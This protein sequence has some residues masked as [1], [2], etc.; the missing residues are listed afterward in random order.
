MSDKPTLVSVPGAWHSTETW[1]KVFSI[2]EAKQFKCVSVAL[3]STAGN[4]ATTF[5]E[6][7][8]AVRDA[9]LEETKQGHDVVVVVHSYGGAVGQ[10]AIKGFS[11]PKQD[12]ASAGKNN[13]SGHVI[14]LAVMG[15]GFGQTG[16][17]F[18]DGLGGKPPPMWREDPSGF[19]VITVPARD[20]FYHDLPEEEGDY[21][22]S[23]LEKQALNALMDPE[24]GKHAYAGWKDVPVWYL[25]TLEDKAF[26]AQFQK[27]MAEMAKEA[28][29]DITVKEIESSHSPM[30]SRPKE[31]AEFISEAVAY[32]TKA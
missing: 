15:S 31:T 10:S 32:F 1:N 19:A 12:V 28:G 25:I 30:L 17:S 14:G 4:I 24:G 3:P 11:R 20:L 22:V 29:A 16:V 6:D 2:L 18:I 21:W 5:G 7:V 27:I 8:E 23:K 13:L 9:I 26:P